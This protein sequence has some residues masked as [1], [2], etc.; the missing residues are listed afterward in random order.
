MAR[1]RNADYVALHFAFL[2][3]HKP[4]IVVGEQH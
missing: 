4:A 2:E 1:Y 3:P